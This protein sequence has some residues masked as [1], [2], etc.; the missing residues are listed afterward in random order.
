[1]KGRFTK[2]EKVCSMAQIVGSMCLALLVLYTFVHRRWKH[3]DNGT[4]IIIY[5]KGLEAVRGIKLFEKRVVI[6]LPFL[7]L[8]AFS[9]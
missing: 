3:R 8:K 1:M 2:A 5:I 6:H 7:S 4:F 9:D